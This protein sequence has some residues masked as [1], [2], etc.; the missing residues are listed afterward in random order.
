[1]ISRLR[2][3]E[4]IICKSLNVLRRYLR[5]FVFQ[6]YSSMRASYEHFP[7]KDLLVSL[8]LAHH[9]SD[10]NEHEPVVVVSEVR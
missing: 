1:M 8:V 9:G 5:G 6:I 10:Y 3:W 2:S 7:G 4:R